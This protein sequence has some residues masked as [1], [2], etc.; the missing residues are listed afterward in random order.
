MAM[1]IPKDVEHEPKASAQAMITTTLIN[2]ERHETGVEYTEGIE[3]KDE[4]P[5]KGKMFD[6]YEVRISRATSE[7]AG[8]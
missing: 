7:R 5:V 6:P 4:L 8:A 3:Y 1:K 2:K